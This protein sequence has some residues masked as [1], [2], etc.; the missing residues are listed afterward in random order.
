MKKLKKSLFF[1]SLSLLAVPALAADEASRLHDLFKREWEV[2]L[3]EDPLLATSVGRH[4]YD[5]RLPSATLADLQRQTGEAKAFLAE[6]DAIDRAKLPAIDQVNYDIF[7]RQLEN[8]IA[9]FE[10]G[11]YQMPFNA[12]SG[13]PSSFSRLPEEVPLATV[14]DYRNYV[15][16]LRAWPRYVHEQ[17]ELMRTGI[18]RGFTVPRETLNGYDKSISAHMVDD[19]AKSVF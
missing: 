7:K 16:R 5:D 3:K 10:L 19:P 8:G 4:E 9:G 15:S 18:Q 6:L 11:D 14:K 13:F 12:D 17:I 1:L 2:R